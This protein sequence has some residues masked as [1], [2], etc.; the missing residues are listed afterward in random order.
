MWNKTIL[1]VHNNTNFIVFHCFFEIYGWG[2]LVFYA[3]ISEL[4]EN[5]LFHEQY[6]ELKYPY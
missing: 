5:D 1:T 4:F 3:Y 2:E 6:E